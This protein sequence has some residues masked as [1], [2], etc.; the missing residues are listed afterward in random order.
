M[1]GF[2]NVDRTAPSLHDELPLSNSDLSFLYVDPDF[3]DGTTTWLK[4]YFFVLN[5]IFRATLLPKIGDASKVQKL[6]RNLLNHFGDPVERFSV[7]SLIWNEIRL[8]P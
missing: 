6:S 3:A 5:N 7:S 4:S 8:T 2:G 1:F